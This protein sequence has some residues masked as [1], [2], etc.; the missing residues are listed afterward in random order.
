MMCQNCVNIQPDV[1]PIK[2]IR[3]HDLVTI[4]TQQG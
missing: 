4:V 2:A 3:D 1:Q